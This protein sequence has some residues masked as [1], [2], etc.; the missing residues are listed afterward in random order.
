MIFTA[1]CLLA[2]AVAAVS[3]PDVLLTPVT[4]PLIGPPYCC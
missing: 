2:A 4:P 3:G 1:A